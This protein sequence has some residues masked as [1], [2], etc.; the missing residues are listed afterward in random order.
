[1]LTSYLPY[2]KVRCYILI[3]IKR[4]VLKKMNKNLREDSISSLIAKFAIPVII[5]L[6]VNAVYNIVDR[7]FI[8]NYVGEEALASLMIVFPIMMFIFALSVLIG[9]GASNLISIRLGENKEHQANKIFTNTIVLNT[10]IILV[11]AGISLYF[12]D[13]ILVFIGA[14]GLVF[15]YAKT[16]LSVY[17]F[18]T[19]VAITSY[20]LSTVV[21]AEGYP[22]LSMY[23]MVLSG[24]TNILFDYIF[25][26]IM[27]MGVAGAALA[28]GIGQ[29][30]GFII[31]LLHFIR[32]KSSLHIEKESL[33]PD[34]NVVKDIIVIGFPS[35]LSMVGVSLFMS[36]FNVN[37]NKYG[38]VPAVTAM[39]A[40]NSLFTIIIMPINGLQGGVQPIIGFNHGAKLTSRVRETIIKGIIIGCSFSTVAFIVIE[41]MPQVLLSMF[42]DTN[43]NTMPIA[44]TGLRIFMLSLPLISINILAV[45]Y[46]QATQR[47]KTAMFLGLLRQFFLLIPLI[48]ILPNL[49]NL[50]LVGV[51]LAVPVA[52]F[53][54]IIITVILLKYDFKKEDSSI[55]LN[56]EA[57][58][59][60]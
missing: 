39:A 26:C 8:S 10:I 60:M 4:K 37:L 6:L 1:M 14:T 30:L 52:D 45:A 56:M 35:F 25:I 31:L 57:S 38:G 42:I 18:F 55:T 44:V 22:N 20:I 33:L 24:L 12:L 9:N 16:Y 43:S 29:T 36:V 32:K 40:I 27:G 50:G 47:A 17:L 46:F 23:S 54:G 21:R 59:L 58:P 3:Y 19:P 49:F 48:L 28:T 15:D 34:I 2:K 5:G 53:I 7:I 13:D 51:W 41:S 11:I